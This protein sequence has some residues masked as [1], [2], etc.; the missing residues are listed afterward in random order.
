M[1]REFFGPALFVSAIGSAAAFLCPSLSAT[2][3]GRPMVVSGP[4][5]AGLHEAR[6]NAA[7]CFPAALLGEP[8]VGRAESGHAA[9]ALTFDRGPDGV[10]IG[11]DDAFE[12]DLAQQA[13]IVVLDADG[14][15][16]AAGPAGEWT[17]TEFGHGSSSA[18]G[19]SHDGKPGLI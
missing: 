6:F 3:D 10:V 11:A 17:P 16:I 1:V 13:L 5:V 19:A 8:V 4:E 18:C 14:R 12:T 9:L 7:E 2:P 15:V